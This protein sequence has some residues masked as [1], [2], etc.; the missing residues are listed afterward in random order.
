MVLLKKDDTSGLDAA[1]AQQLCSVSIQASFSHH[2]GDF[3]SVNAQV[4]NAQCKSIDIACAISPVGSDVDLT[5]VD[6]SGSMNAEPI[7]LDIDLVTPSGGSCPIGINCFKHF[8][9]P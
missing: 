8:Q 2:E 4:G 5:L 1:D 3:L 9:H 6:F 7:N